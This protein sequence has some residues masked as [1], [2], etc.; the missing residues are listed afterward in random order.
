MSH[1]K[2]LKMGFFPF[3]PHSYLAITSDSKFNGT[4]KL[5]ATK[6]QM[7][8]KKVDGQELSTVTDIK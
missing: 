3:Y 6:P 5:D 1:V 8:D 7:R 4:K 2:I